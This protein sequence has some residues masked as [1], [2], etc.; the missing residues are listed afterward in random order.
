IKDAF[1]EGMDWGAYAKYIEDEKPDIL[2]IGGMTP[3]IDTS[4][5]AIKIARRHVRHIIMGGPHLS[6]YRQQV[7][8]QC[9]EVDFGVAGEGEETT[10][11]L[12]CMTGL[13]RRGPRR[14]RENGKARVLCCIGWCLDGNDLAM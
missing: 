7:F 2:G 14:Q 13:F 6:L 9:P 3:V 8:T 4:F 5:K 1:A 10:L 11:A 12:I